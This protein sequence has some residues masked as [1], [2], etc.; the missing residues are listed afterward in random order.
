MQCTK[1]LEPLSFEEFEDDIAEEESQNSLNPR[2]NAL[3]ALTDTI[4]RVNSVLNNETDSVRIKAFEK[5]LGKKVDLLNIQIDDFVRVYDSIVVDSEKKIDYYESINE[6]DSAASV[7]QEIDH[8]THTKTEILQV[9]DNNI[10]HLL[11]EEGDREGERVLE[12]SSSDQTGLSMVTLPPS[13]EESSVVAVYSHGEKLSSSSESVGVSDEL[14]VVSS[15]AMEASISSEERYSTGREVSS[16]TLVESAESKG[17]S[18]SENNSFVTPSV[19]ADTTEVL[20]VKASNEYVQIENGV[21]ADFQGNGL[22]MELWVEWDKI[23]Q[24]AHLI[25]LSNGQ[26]NN[27][28]IALGVVIEGSNYKLQYTVCNAK[29]GTDEGSWGGLSLDSVFVPHKWS[30]VAITVTPNGVAS[31]YI[32][33]E[34][35]VRTE[36]GRKAVPVNTAR[37]VNYLGKSEEPLDGH[38]YG[39]MDNVRIWNRA[40][41]ADEIV[42]NLYHTTELLEDTSGLLLSYDFEYDPYG[43]LKVQD[44]SGKNTYGNLRGMTGA[45]GYLGNWHPQVDFRQR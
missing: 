32:D 28:M 1:S 11:L 18:S 10:A 25:H 16:S 24:Y 38:F 17:A 5:A 40:R 33:G 39:R 34:E 43:P 31:F 21:N 12:L 13:I 36:S 2:V 7:R 27:Y 23:E 22:T 37:W 3:I 42:D 6:T 35:K 4:N 19:L 20:N 41:T 26:Y 45:L 29:D 44:K 15:D 9:I 8:L 30:H 14:A